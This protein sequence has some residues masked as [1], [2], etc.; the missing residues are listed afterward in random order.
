MFFFFYGE[1]A[2]N[3]EISGVYLTNSGK[4]QEQ[5]KIRKNKENQESL[6]RLLKSSF[7]MLI[8][9]WISNADSLLDLKSNYIYHYVYEFT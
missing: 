1:K 4:N 5:L 8:H 9:S 3:Q 7:N 2:Q 6:D